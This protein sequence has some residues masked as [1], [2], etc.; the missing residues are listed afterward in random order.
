[1]LPA[2]SQQYRPQPEESVIE[3]GRVPTILQPL[4]N[5]RF[6]AYA[7]AIT[8]SSAGT[9]AATV[10]LSF[11]I[12]QSAGPAQLA[13]V[14]LAREVPLV[15]L[16]LVG[17][18]VADRFSRRSVLIVT[19]LVQ[20][21]SQLAAAGVLAILGAEGLGTALLMACA[22][23][24]GGAAAFARPAMAGMVPEL[25]AA[26]EIQPANAVLGLAPRIIGIAG[27]TVGAVLVSAVG[28][29]WALAFDAS[30]FV[31]AAAFFV[32]LGRTTCSRTQER[33]SPVRSFVEG[34]HV[35]RGTPWIWAM[36]LS[37]GMF[38][39][40]YFPAVSVLGPEV[41]RTTYDGAISWAFL[42]SAGLVGGIIGLLVAAKI[43]PRRPLLTV[44]L[45]GI[46]SALQVAAL[47]QGWWVGLVAAC[48]VLG[49]VGLA[50]GDTLWMTSLHSNVDPEKIGRVSSFDWLGSLTFNPLGYA[51]IAPLAAWAGARHT[52]MAAA[53]VLA[54]AALLPLASRD[55][56]TLELRTADLAATQ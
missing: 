55:V 18:V 29:A 51:V 4:R 53:C 8:I 47:A 38:Q 43:R 9:Y 21:T 39:L 1:L 52:L 24:N 13:L 28:A 36:I 3:P 31:V 27:A 50:I 2:P 14:L 16:V 17:G 41:A 49:G 34:W 35:V 20:A 23:I 33:I 32:T 45:V 10:A 11:G 56:R 22:A 30:T 48:A 5:R 42:L 46:P 6:A 12:L 37:F 7:V 25:V 40:A 44:C 19:S 26:D 15:V 54:L